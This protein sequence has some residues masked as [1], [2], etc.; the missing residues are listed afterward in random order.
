MVLALCGVENQVARGNIIA[1][2]GFESLEDLSILEDDKDVSEMAKRM[3]GR[4]PNQGHVHLST[5]TIKRL[6]ALVSCIH[7]C[8][9][10]NLPLNAALTPAVLTDAIKQKIVQNKQAEAEITTKDLA[11]FEPDDFDTHEDAF[12]TCWLRHMAFRMSPFDMSF[13]QR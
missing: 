6:Q 3:A 11:K 2:E 8:Q 12:F 4:V 9:K 1:W 13:V 10:L 5:V 7:D